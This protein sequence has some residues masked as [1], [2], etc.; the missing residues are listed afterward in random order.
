MTSRRQLLNEIRTAARV[1]G[2]DV[3]EASGGRGPHDKLV[4]GGF[5]V[6]IPRHRE[7]NRLTAEGIRKEP[8]TGPWR[9]VVAGMRSV[10]VARARRS[11]R[12]WA[13]TVDERPGIHS[14]CKR[15]DRVEAM[16][17][18]AV[19]FV[20]RVDPSEVQ[21]RLEVELSTAEQRAM[22]RAERKRLKADAAA[23]DAAKAQLELVALL[24]ADGLSVRDIGRLLGLSAQRI[25]QLEAQA[26][27]SGQAA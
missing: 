5:R 11:D 7:I 23:R 24:R 19:S 13:I 3:I 26:R 8:P 6:T 27:R 18:D 14:Q 16:A 17:R 1:R 15:L 10:Y 20:D 12:W 21:I 25:S 4:V 2:I 9:E 22:S